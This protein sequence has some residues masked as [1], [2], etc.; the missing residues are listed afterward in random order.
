MHPNSYLDQ[1]WS[2]E[3]VDEVFVAMSFHEDYASRFNLVFKPAIE[4]VLVNGVR[5]QAN[6]V[7]ER[8]SGDSIITE[9]LR[10]ISQARLILADVSDLNP[11]SSY[12]G[13]HRNGNVMYEL[14]IAHAAK[15]PA[16]VMIVRDDNAKL[17]FD[18]SS[19]P[20]TTIDFQNTSAAKVVVGNLIADRL[21][22][23]ETVIDIKLRNF[24]STMTPG[25]LELLERLAKCPIEQAMRLD[26][27][28]AGHNVTPIPTN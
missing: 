17:L 4:S 16:Q 23:C 26:I 7:D 5:L 10:G 13:I 21:R 22:E 2:G 24:L 14:G 6:R 18:I 11:G 15:S 12:K 9:M 20:H 1:V 25:E 27:E 19:I 8:K 3:E 28:V